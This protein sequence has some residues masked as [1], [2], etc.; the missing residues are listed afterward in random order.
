MNFGPDRLPTGKKLRIL[1]VVDPHLLNFPAASA[2]CTDQGE[3][4]IQTLAG[5]CRKTG[6]LKT[7]RGDYGSWCISHDLDLW[8]YANNTALDFSRGGKPTGSSFIETLNSMLRPEGL[9]THWFRPLPD[10]REKLVTWRRYSN[11]EGPPS[12]IGYH[13]PIALHNLGGATGQPS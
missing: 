12:A 1:T 5:I 6:Y 10:S 11:E 9:N 13:V 4:V 8:T 3:D 2:R 7:I